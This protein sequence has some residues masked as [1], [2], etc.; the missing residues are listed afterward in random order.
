MRIDI[1]NP[2][3]QLIDFTL[4]I[5]HDIFNTTATKDAF[6]KD[7]HAILDPW[8]PKIESSKPQGDK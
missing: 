5:S 4:E 6:R 8:F 2:Q 3:R 1:Y 7:L